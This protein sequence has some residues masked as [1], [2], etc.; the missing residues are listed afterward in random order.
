MTTDYVGALAALDQRIGVGI[1]PGLER[2][3]GLLE[4]LAEPQTT[5]PVI[6][7]AGTNGKTSTARM[8]AALLSAHGLATG[9]FTSPHLRRINERFEIAGDPITDQAF[10]DLLAVTEPIA[11][12]FEQREDTQI[13]Y[14]EITTAMAYSWF[15]AEAVDVAV[16]E[17]GLGGRWDATSVADRMTC[18]G[19]P[20]WRV[21]T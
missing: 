10:A 21:A 1:R 6:Q 17:T 15:A 12:L 19:S 18:R 5:F 4:M 20:G 14:F 13:T 3:R 2:V 7:V 9:L 8:I 16:V 11:R